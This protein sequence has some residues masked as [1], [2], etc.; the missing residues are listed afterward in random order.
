[1]LLTIDFEQLLHKRMSARS[2][3]FE[4]ALAERVAVLVEPALNVVADNAGVVVDRKM[5]HSTRFLRWTR[6]S[7]RWRFAQMRLTQLLRQ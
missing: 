1:M 6:L 4:Q 3:H 5:R 7:E 2:Q